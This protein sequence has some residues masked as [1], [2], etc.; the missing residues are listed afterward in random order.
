MS[1]NL[2]RS[3]WGP[4]RSHKYCQSRIGCRKLDSPFH[5]LDSPAFHT[6]GLNDSVAATARICPNGSE[7]KDHAGFSVLRLDCPA[8]T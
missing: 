1:A 8:K 6:N 3:V 4:G 7:K 2:F 5:M